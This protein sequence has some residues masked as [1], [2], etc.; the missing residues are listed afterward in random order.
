M[1]I[2][3]FWLCF[4]WLGAASGEFDC[5]FTLKMHVCGVS[6]WCSACCVFRLLDSDLLCLLFPTCPCSQFVGKGRFQEQT[7]FL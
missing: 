3:M 1:R 6:M 4:P 7:R 5:V 2:G